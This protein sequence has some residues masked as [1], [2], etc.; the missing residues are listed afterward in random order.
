MTAPKTSRIPRI[1]L[2][3]FTSFAFLNALLDIV[4]RGFISSTALG[5][6]AV[7]TLASIALFAGLVRFTLY[8]GGG[9]SHR[10]VLW[11]F[12]WGAACVGI[13]VLV[14]PA[15]EHLVL[16]LGGHDASASF[17]GAW[18]EEILK[19]LGVLLFAVACARREFFFRDVLTLGIFVGLGFEMIENISYGV[20]G[21]LSHP[22][23]DYLGTQD[24]WIN[25]S[26]LFPFLHLIFT[27]VASYGIAVSLWWRRWLPGVASVLVGFALHFAW[28]YRWDEAYALEAALV[29]YC[30]GAGA[31]LWAAVKMARGRGRHMVLVT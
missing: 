25:R 6:G 8:R 26:V 11:G 4:F 5:F 1:L 7:A 21:A 27:V 20:A 24:Q 19:G 30:L 13:A 17:A 18:P 23:N 15:S 2:Y 28:N 14:N 10:L 16:A 22:V 9:Y 3:V 12:A 29:I 31:A